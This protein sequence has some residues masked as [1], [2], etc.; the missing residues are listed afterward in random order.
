MEKKSAQK[1]SKFMTNNTINI[2]ADISMNGQMLEEVTNFKYLGAT[3]SKDG[4]FQQKSR[5][6]LPQQWPD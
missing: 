5:S 1:K 4:T 2:S 3:Q 6:G